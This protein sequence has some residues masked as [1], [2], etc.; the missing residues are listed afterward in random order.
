ML[1]YKVPRNNSKWQSKSKKVW[2]VIFNVRQPF[3]KLQTLIEPLILEAVERVQK[4]PSQ[5][6]STL[7]AISYFNINPHVIN[8]CR[9]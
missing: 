1:D 9:P 3:V 8:E 7:N 5:N 6:V 4:D 2:P